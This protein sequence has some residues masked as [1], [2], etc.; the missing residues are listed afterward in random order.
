MIDVFLVHDDVDRASVIRAAIAANPELNLVSES[1]TGR[2]GAFAVATI[3]QGHPR[4]LIVRLNL[5]D[6]NGFDF[7]N[8]IKA[9]SPDVY[10][11]PALEGNEGG[12][13]WQ[14]LLQLELRDVIMGQVPQLEVAKVI[15][16]AAGRAQVLFDANKAASSAMVGEAFVVSVVSARGG[17]GKSVIAT[18][19]A[20]GIAKQSDSVSLLDF[21]LNPGDFAVMLDDV[22]RNNIMDAVAAGGN[23][24]AELLQNLLAPHPRLGFRY[25]ACPNQDFDPSAFDYNVALAMM[26]AMRSLSQYIVVDT[27]LSA[28]GPTIA[29]VDSSDIIFFLTSRDVARL[30]GAQRFIKYL[31]NDRGIPNQKIKV[32]VNEAE[33]GAEISESEIESLLEHPVTAYLPCNAAPVTYSINSG[34]PIVISEPHHPVAV[35]LA[36]L[37]E[38][39]YNRW[40][41]RAPD[42]DSAKTQRVTKGL[43]A[44]LSQKL[45]IGHR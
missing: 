15:K 18:N 24:D 9:K 17:V 33:V 41:E 11:V 3:L 40:Q 6:I 38:L 14:N 43:G 28:S 20:A 5:G 32:L 23:L 29:A 25:L 22:P 21:S 39:S 45:N 26:N 36:K 35:V 16:S 19:L 34:S 7:I 30:L 10:I 12:Q 42:A 4:L 13:V 2:E 1:Q 31:K 37:A 8:Q 27:G 44:K